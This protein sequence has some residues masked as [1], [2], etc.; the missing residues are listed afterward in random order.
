MPFIF[1]PG[2][3]G[4]IK[5]IILEN[6]TKQNHKQNKYRR[7]KYGPPP[8]HS[9]SFMCVPMTQQRK[10]EVYRKRIQGPERQLKEKDD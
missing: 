4:R 8:T 2:T 6:K 9:I 5:V 1:G 3:G 10:P 7:Y